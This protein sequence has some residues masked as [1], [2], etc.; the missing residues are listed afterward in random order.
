[1]PKPP[2]K[3]SKSATPPPPPPPPPPQQARPQAPPQGMRPGVPAPGI[4][5]VIPA[6]SGSGDIGLGIAVSTAPGET[7]VVTARRAGG[8][9]DLGMDVNPGRVGEKAALQ[10]LAKAVNIAFQTD[11]GEN[12]LEVVYQAAI[13]R[14]GEIHIVHKEYFGFGDSWFGQLGMLIKSMQLSFSGPDPVSPEGQRAIA[15]KGPSTIRGLFNLLGRKLDLVAEF[16][17]R[18]PAYVE[19]M[20]DRLE[21]SGIIVGWNRDDWEISTT[22]VGL[23]ILIKPVG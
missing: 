20:F 13:V 6:P 1:M 21:A 16:E 8:L 7:G 5:P 9:R 19:Q 17:D 11:Y 12:Y 2:P 22:S 10:H 23:N 3:S 15:E 18:V 4:P 14:R